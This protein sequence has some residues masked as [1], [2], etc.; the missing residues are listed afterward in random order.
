[1]TVS[2]STPQRGAKTPQQNKSKPA[3]ASGREGGKSTAKPAARFKLM[4]FL[5]DVRAEGGKITWPTRRVTVITSI[6]VLAMAA[7]TSIFFFVVDQLIGLGVREIL[8]F[9]G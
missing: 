8:G 3:A 7:L 4:Q 6:A 9:G 1:M 2:V 5:K